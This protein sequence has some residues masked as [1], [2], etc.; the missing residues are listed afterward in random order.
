MRYALSFLPSVATPLYQAGCLWLGRATSTGRNSSQPLLQGITPD[1]LWELACYPRNFGLQA[2]VKFPFRLAPNVTKKTLCEILQ[3]FAIQQTPVAISNLK[4]SKNVDIFHLEAKDLPTNLLNLAGNAIKT[5]NQF[6]AP[7]KPSEYARL[8]AGILSIQ[9]KNIETWRY[10]YVFDQYR[11]KIWLTSRI[12]HSLE[13][14]VIY[15]ALNRYFSAACA[16][17][18]MI[19]AICLFVENGPGTPLRFSHRFSFT[20]HPS[21]KMDR[22]HYA[23]NTTKD[24]YSRYQRSAS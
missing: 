8:K 15:S 16:D 17:P 12:T 22:H 7:L 21:E 19:D 3:N 18:L 11:F 1:R 14:E 6:C 13:K 2:V 23:N 10:P 24:I 5:L 20:P 9:E 4:L